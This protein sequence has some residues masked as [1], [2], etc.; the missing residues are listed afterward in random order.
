M[1]GALVS[2][3][4]PAPSSPTLSAAEPRTRTVYVTALDSK[5]APVTDL[6]AADFSVKEGGKERE[7]VKAEIGSAPIQVSI[8]VDDNGSGLFRVG[9]ANFLQKLLGH[10][11]FAITTVN[12]QP[13]KIVDYTKDP[14]ALR[15]ALDKLGPRP[16]TPD[17]GQLLSGISEAAV[18]LTKRKAERPVI[19]ALSVPAD[20]LSPLTGH[21]VLN[22]LR[23]S[24]A[25]LHVISVAASA[26]RSTTPT[27]KP[28]DSFEGPINIGQVLGDGPKQ[29][30]GRSEEIVAAVGIVAGLLR[31]A[32]D[33]LNQYAISY[34][35]PDGVKLDERFSISTKR[36][37][38]TLRAP[39]RIPDK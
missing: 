16:A 23:D 17:G 12:G 33:L 14:Q 19:V 30:G 39:S 8:I 21:Q 2:L 20:D 26:I 5:G 34:T 37:G 6:S 4:I 36:K 31:I 7:I 38:V 27:S 22:Q 29:S 28:A 18:E 24:T 13:M 35:L 9:I 1:A 11:E 32:D 25:S 3:W 15:A 10:G